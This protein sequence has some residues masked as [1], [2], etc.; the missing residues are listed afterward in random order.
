METIADSLDELFEAGGQPARALRPFV[1]VCPPASRWE[2]PD[3]FEPSPSS[4]AQALREVLAGRRRITIA[5]R[6][7]AAL[8]VR[9]VSGEWSVEAASP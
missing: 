4:Y 8:A 7:G 5:G 3:G 9:A 6:D 2:Q 1:A